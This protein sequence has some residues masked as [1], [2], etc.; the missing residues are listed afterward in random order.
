MPF[1]EHQVIAALFPPAVVT[2]VSDDAATGEL[3]GEE[4]TAVAN[5]LEKRRREF[6]QGRA[7]AREA[8]RRLGVEPAPIPA[9]AD[10]APIWPEGIVGTIT[11]TAGL[12]AAAV[13]RTSEVVALGMDAESRAR[14]LKTGLERFIRTEAE[15][16]ACRLPLELDPVRLVFSAKESIHKCVAPMSR[17]R[18]NFHEVELEFD[19]ARASFRATLV[20]THHRGLPNF[21]N[22][23]G[24]F[25]VTSDYVFTSATIRSASAP[26]LPHSGVA[27]ALRNGFPEEI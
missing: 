14:P 15:R 6:A 7:C 19:V 22:I 10:R 27:G 3:L 9:R 2:I 26:V 21:E 12:V 4:E 24:R 8:M 13:A 5:S 20:P 25:A 23:E 11:H 16:D 18:L 1:T 17:I